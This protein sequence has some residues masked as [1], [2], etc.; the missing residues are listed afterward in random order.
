M[1]C[2]NKVYDDPSVLF[3][4]M[5]CRLGQYPGNYYYYYYHH[6]HHHPPPPFQTSCCNAQCDAQNG[7]CY[8]NT[9]VL[10]QQFC[11]LK[12]TLENTPRNSFYVLGKKE[13]YCILRHAAY[14]LFYFP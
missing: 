4:Q 3:L 6:H 8:V 2:D 10:M 11:R 14:S 12:H 9:S 7:E 1:F 5:C 13:I